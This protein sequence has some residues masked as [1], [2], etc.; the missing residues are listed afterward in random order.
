MNA[1]RMAGILL[2]AGWLGAVQADRYVVEPGTPGGTDTPPFNTWTNA[3]TNIQSA[4]NAAGDGEVVL[5]SNGTYGATGSGTAFVGV[6]ALYIDK[7]VRVQSVNGPAFTMLDGGYPVYTNR[8]V[9]LN[10][11]GAVFSGFTVMRGCAA[12]G[13]GALIGSFGGVITNCLIISNIADRALGTDGGGG[14]ATYT[15][16]SYTGYVDNCTIQGNVAI[17]NN[18]GGGWFRSRAV[19]QNCDFVDNV[20]SQGV[21]RGGG[22]Y[23]DGGIWLIGCLILL[24]LRRR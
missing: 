13:G 12:R 15:T 11:T 14:L 24:A 20:C 7:N 21:G 17:S 10:K 18:G 3:A 2:A 4:V 22:I 1:K 19:I 16:T 23:V 9:C 8:L 6:N 5:V